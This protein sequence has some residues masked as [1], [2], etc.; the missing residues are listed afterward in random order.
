MRYY[1]LSDL[2][3]FS[4]IFPLI[5]TNC[6]NRFRF[7]S[8]VIFFFSKNLR[9][10][11]V[12]DPRYIQAGILFMETFVKDISLVYNVESETTCNRESK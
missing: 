3:F 8:Y 4:N 5:Q 6:L 10:L 11:F 7:K 12:I 1:I 2:E 9:M